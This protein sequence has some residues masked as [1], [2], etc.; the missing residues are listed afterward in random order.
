MADGCAIPSYYLS[1]QRHG[2]CGEAMPTRGRREGRESHAAEGSQGANATSMTLPCSPTTYCCSMLTW[3][4]R[5]LSFFLV[6]TRAVTGKRSR[7][8]GP[9]VCDGATRTPHSTPHARTAQRAPVGSVDSLRMTAVGHRA[10]THAAAAAAL[11]AR[12]YSTAL[13]NRHLASK[14]LIFRIFQISTILFPLKNRNLW[15]GFS[16]CCFK[17]DSVLMI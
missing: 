7:D 17:P 2:P 14:P 6:Q 12:A 8:L 5:V 16:H 3:V 13:L 10:H 9:G 11:V 4:L 1:Y 15:F